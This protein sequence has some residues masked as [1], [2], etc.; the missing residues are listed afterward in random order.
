M[1]ERVP[2]FVCGDPT[3]G[4]DG[5]ALAAVELLG[6]EIRGRIDLVPVGQ[7]D[8]VALLDLPA[9]R[10]CV[11]VDAVAGIEPGQV[12]VQ[13]LAALVGR[14]R[15]LRSAGLAVEPRSSHELPL[16][17]AL[18]LATALRDRPPA[19]VFVGIGGARWEAGA[20]LSDAVAAGLPAFAAAIEAAIGE[21]AGA[22]QAA[23]A[24]GAARQGL[25]GSRARAGL[26]RRTTPSA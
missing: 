20:P 14:A 23:G 16:E 4:D 11:V 17:Q 15:R 7:L 12:W 10:A 22:S 26:A 13:S 6:P 18:A 25:G 8:V 2:V 3:R 21:A 24:S 19:G 1:T 9:G 5:A